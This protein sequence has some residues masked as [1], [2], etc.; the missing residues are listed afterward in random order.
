MFPRNSLCLQRGPR[1]TNPQTIQAGSG[2]STSH[3]RKW[4]FPARHLGWGPMASGFRGKC[5]GPLRISPGPGA[6]LSLASELLSSFAQ[7]ETWFSGNPQS[8]HSGCWLRTGLGSVCTRSWELRQSKGTVDP[9]G[10]FMRPPTTLLAP[11]NH[12]IAGAEL[13]FCLRPWENPQRKSRVP[14]LPCS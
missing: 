11:S 3:A 1:L 7:K 6:H 14:S 5:G 8:S 12:Q 4:P 9:V 10:S 2:Q 13:V